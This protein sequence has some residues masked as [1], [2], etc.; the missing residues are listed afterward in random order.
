ME[1]FD[2]LHFRQ[3]LTYI[4][5][6]LAKCYVFSVAGYLYTALV[7]LQ[8]ICVIV[9]YINQLQHNVQQIYLNLRFET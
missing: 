3:Y 4:D 2:P 9:W 5:V 8:D 6:Q 1:N 7:I